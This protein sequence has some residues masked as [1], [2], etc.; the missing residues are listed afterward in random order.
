MADTF[1][2]DSSMIPKNELP[3]IIPITIK[4]IIFGNFIFSNKTPNPN[5]NI[6]TK[7]KLKNTLDH[8]PN[9]KS[10]LKKG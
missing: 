1:N 5:P 7:P 6:K 4:P 8:L 10:N 2:N 9:K 3:N